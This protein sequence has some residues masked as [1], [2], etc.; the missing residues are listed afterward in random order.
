MRNINNSSTIMGMSGAFD[1]LGLMDT[2]QT[3][4]AFTR[5]QTYRR[6]TEDDHHHTNPDD[7][8]I[9][10]EHGGNRGSS[11]DRLSTG[12]GPANP[13]QI[14]THFNTLSQV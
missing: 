8:Q 1:L 7:H 13:A 12:S 11:P 6:V 4:A 5:R 14:H 10:I 3:V 9:S 2:R